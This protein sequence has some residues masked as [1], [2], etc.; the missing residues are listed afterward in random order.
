MDTGKRKRA[1]RSPQTQR[2]DEIESEETGQPQ[3]ADLPSTLLTEI[4]LKLPIMS[5]GKCRCVCKTWFYII[6]NPEFAKLHFSKSPLCI[7]VKNKPPKRESKRLLFSQVF[8]DSGTNRFRYEK[9]NFTSRF[10]LPNTDFRLVNSCNGL[11]CLSG[12]EHKPIYICNPV[13]GEYIT[14]QVPDDSDHS[15]GRSFGLGFSSR[16]NEFKLLYTFKVKQ[17]GLQRDS[18]KALIYTLGA[19]LWRSIENVSHNVRSGKG[20]DTIRSFLG[21]DSFLHGSLHWI[22]YVKHRNG[23]YR[24]IISCFDFD[25]DL[26]GKIPV[27]PQ[28][29]SGYKI[30]LGVYDGCLSAWCYLADGSWEFDV[31]V[32]KEYGV[33]ESWITQFRIKQIRL[34]VYMNFVNNFCFPLIYLKNGEVLFS[35]INEVVVCYNREKGLLR[36]AK[37]FRTLG[38]FN[39]VGYTPS[40]VSLEE[41]VAKGEHLTRTKRAIPF[42]EMYI[43]IHLQGFCIDF[44]NLHF[45]ASA[46]ARL[47]FV[48]FPIPSSPSFTS[49]YHSLALHLDQKQTA[50]A[51]IQ[52]ITLMIPEKLIY[53]C[54]PD[55]GEY[56]TI[57]VPDDSDRLIVMVHLLG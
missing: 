5:L 1:S 13:L 20:F 21:F 43:L 11:V 8:E 44:V 35:F 37:M 6:S 18:I 27:P 46:F 2:D 48:S 30:S 9:M 57:Q 41:Y 45:G 31:C 4:F 26:F 15:Y 55:L 32:M 23:V 39:A 53:V 47:G 54:N 38:K 52:K 17:P 42:M 10:D 50:Q 49:R 51:R 14:I 24:K 3:L 29:K 56:I 34:S 28:F 12:V 40:F 33:K 25:N 19:G 7:L 16:T 36:D 22:S